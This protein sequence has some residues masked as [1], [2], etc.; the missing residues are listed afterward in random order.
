[1]ARLRCLVNP[2][3]IRARAWGV[4]KGSSGANGR[5]VFDERFGLHRFQHCVN[6]AERS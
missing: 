5:R 4:G 3:S 1:M 6:A 2:A